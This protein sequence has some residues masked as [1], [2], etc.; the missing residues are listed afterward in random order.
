MHFSQNVIHESEQVNSYVRGV[1]K[2][3]Q[4][5]EYEKPH[6]HR[7]AE[8]GNHP[9]QPRGCFLC[10]RRLGRRRSDDRRRQSSADAQSP[11]VQQ[12]TLAACS[13]QCGPCWRPVSETVR[14]LSQS[15][16]SGPSVGRTGGDKLASVG[17][18][19]VAVQTI[20]LNNTAIH[21]ITPTPCAVIH[22]HK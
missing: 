9:A 22:D 19:C 18:C 14:S 11:P 5:K 20:A 15:R 7:Q 3:K 16:T 2:K 12:C 21:E 4:Q 6:F 1:Q 17:P 13:D 8:F 10:W